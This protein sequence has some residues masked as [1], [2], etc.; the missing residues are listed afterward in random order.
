MEFSFSKKKRITKSLEISKLFREGEFFSCSGARLFLRNN[1]LEFNRIV[2][3]LSRKYGTAVER[4]RSKRLSRECYRLIQNDLKQG[5]DFSF[6]VYPGNDTFLHRKNQL[7]YLFS[8]AGILIK[9]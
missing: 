5:F 1:G 2:F 8:K 9:N 4:N 6:L 7:E 3:T